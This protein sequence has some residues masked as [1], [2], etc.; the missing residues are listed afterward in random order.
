MFKSN[1][2]STQHSECQC[3]W[4]SYSTAVMINSEYFRLFRIVN[5]IS[6]LE[7][8][9]K[10][11]I[12]NQGPNRLVS[13]MNSLEW[14]TRYLWSSVWNIRFYIFCNLKVKNTGFTFANS[15]FPSPFH[16]LIEYLGSVLKFK[17]RKSAIIYKPRLK[18]AQILQI[19]TARPECLV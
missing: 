7:I 13:A 6:N 15:L 5:T 17:G 9:K 19:S 11:E 2:A 10:K 12:I 8:L 16:C 14:L 3:K 18:K 4:I 1:F